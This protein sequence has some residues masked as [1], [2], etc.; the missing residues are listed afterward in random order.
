M[1]SSRYQSAGTTTERITREYLQSIGIR[2]EA[3]DGAGGADGLRAEMQEEAQ[4]RLF[5]L[6]CQ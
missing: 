5:P 2:K 4:Q 3:L 6:C 1:I